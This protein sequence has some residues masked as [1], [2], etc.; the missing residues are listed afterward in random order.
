MPQ[1]S[2]TCT[3]RTL[4]RAS[5]PGNQPR[6]V[7]DWPDGLRLT[8]RRERM[9]DG[10]IAV[11]LSPH[12]SCRGPISHG[13]CPVTVRLYAMTCHRWRLLANS[14]RTAELLTVSS[15]KGPHFAVWDPQ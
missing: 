5:R 10:R 11:H 9:S 12:R 7:F 6:H 14:S 3:S 4:P 15:R 1:Q 13:E 8:V 2:S